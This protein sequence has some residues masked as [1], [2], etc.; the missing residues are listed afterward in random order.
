MAALS[1]SISLHF[2][3]SSTLRY[4]PIQLTPPSISIAIS[5]APTAFP[6]TMHITKNTFL[7]AIVLGSI[8]GAISIAVPVHG[9]VSSVSKRQADFVPQSEVD[10]QATGKLRGC[11]LP[12]TN[13]RH[14]TLNRVKAENQTPSIKIKMQ[15]R[16][17]RGTTPKRRSSIPEHLK[18]SRIPK[19]PSIKIRVVGLVL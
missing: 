4:S 14:K 17:G 16:G 15:P 5:I 7:S 6:H 18:R 11:E 2:L 10:G 3:R 19:P 1:S 13:S 12:Q 9:E 8:T